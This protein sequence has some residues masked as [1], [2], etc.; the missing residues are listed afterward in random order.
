MSFEDLHDY[1][2]FL[3]NRKDLVKIDDTVDPDLE[4]TYI[5][6]EEERVGKGRAIMFSNVKESS[7]SAVGNLFSTHEKMRYILGE[8]P[9]TLGSR[10][11]N[12]CLRGIN[13]P[14]KHNFK[15]SRIFQIDRFPFD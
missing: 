14:F 2:S 8:D 5:L 10:I 12:P 3:L 4:L 15:I 1:I 9:N 11:T 6:S 7:I 13:I